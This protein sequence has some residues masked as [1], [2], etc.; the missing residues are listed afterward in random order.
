MGVILSLARP[1]AFESAEAFTWQPDVRK[2]RES[3]KSCP[4]CAAILDLL[5]EPKFIEATEKFP[6]MDTDGFFP[7]SLK[8]D[9]I[10]HAGPMS[11]AFLNVELQVEQYA[12]HFTC[13]G[14]IAVSVAGYET[15]TSEFCLIC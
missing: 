6:Q 12:C 9:D 2:L 4:L 13:D 1:S 11:W 14:N 3:K 7:L 15:S 10:R 5:V 8:L